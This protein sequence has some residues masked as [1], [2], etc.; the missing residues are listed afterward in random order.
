MPRFWGWLLR[1]GAVAPAT[2]ITEWYDRYQR[3]MEMAEEF[4][5]ITLGESDLDDER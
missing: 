5:G 1:L 2:V 3:L 4:G